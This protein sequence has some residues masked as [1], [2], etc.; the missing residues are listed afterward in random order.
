MK[1]GIL[2]AGLGERLRAGGIVTPKCLVR[3]A[4]RT[5]LSHALRAVQ[6]AG[7]SE[8]L[9]AVN[10]RDAD[11]VEAALRD[12]PPPIPATLLRRSTASSLETFACLSIQLAD[13]ARALAA[14][15]DGVF[16]PGAASGFGEEAR[17]LAHEPPADAAE[18]LIG[19]TNRPDEDRPLRVAFD[20]AR[21]IGAIGPAAASSRWCTAGLYL[22][23]QRA[24]AMAPDALAEGL[25]AL[26]AFLARLV[27]SGVR[28]R[29]YPLGCVV[30]VDRPDDLMA[31]E[32]MGGGA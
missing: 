26:R 20:A 22:L 32:R 6:Q 23:P 13:E 12:E 4:G 15:V 5:L 2:A 18:G 29:A 7:A 19:V 30:D 11:S 1:A 14:M 24:F 27:E 3:V 9:V 10:D 16:E 21:H 17:L 25:G 28:L 8:A 31:A